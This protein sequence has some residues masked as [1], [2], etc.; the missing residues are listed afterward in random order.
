MREILG[1]FCV[2]EVEIFDSLNM[3]EM[4]LV[5]TDFSKQAQNVL[6]LSNSQV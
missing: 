4:L 2:C 5:S 1:A 6:S 3:S